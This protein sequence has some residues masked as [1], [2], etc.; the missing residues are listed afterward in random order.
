MENP[1][2]QVNQVRGIV[3]VPYGNS[4]HEKNKRIKRWI[5]SR[6][7]KKEEKKERNNRNVCCLFDCYI[8]CKE[9]YPFCIRSGCLSA[10]WTWAGNDRQYARTTEI[11][12]TLG[13]SINGTVMVDC[14]VLNTDLKNKKK[15]KKKW[16]IAKNENMI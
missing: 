2:N 5:N 15:N 7:Y 10:W 1:V 11:S 4:S 13:L 6:D 9:R 3:T 14:I 8:H 12:D 16:L